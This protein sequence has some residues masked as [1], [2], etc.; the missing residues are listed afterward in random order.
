MFT[1]VLT[2]LMTVQAIFKQRIS[3]HPMRGFSLEQRGRSS[4][5]SLLELL[6]VLFILAV[7]FA[8]V[9]SLLTKSIVVSR[10]IKN[11]IIAGNLAAEAIEVVINIR[12]SNWLVQPTSDPFDD[13]DGDGLSDPP[14]V[15]TNIIYS[16]IGTFDEV[17]DSLYLETIGGEL[18]Y[19]HNPSGTEPTPFSRKLEINSFIDADGVSYR[20]V[21][22][23]VTWIQFGTTKQLVLI[24]HLY[25]WKPQ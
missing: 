14:S 21:K 2:R 9:F 12:N 17:D 8:A 24:D 6:F 19:T 22:S 20:E 5:F 18:F 10:Q 25:D 7:G 15:T 11:E 3:L 1:A 13:F 23:T 16:S 4:G